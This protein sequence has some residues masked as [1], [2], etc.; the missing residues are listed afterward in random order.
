MSRSRRW[1][2]AGALLIPALAL[3]GAA[4]WMQHRVARRDESG[5][6]RLVVEHVERQ[7]A[8]ARDVA[9]GFDTRF[10]VAL[11]HRGP[12]PEAWGES[13]GTR[14]FGQ[15]EQL[16]ADSRQWHSWGNERVSCRSIDFDAASNTY[17]STFTTRL[18][19]VPAR[20]GEVRMKLTIA[21]WSSGNSN[22]PL[23]DAI[24]E[25]RFEFV[26]RQAGERIT[27]PKV[28]HHF[29][30]KAPLVNVS[31]TT[32]TSGT[33][34]V[35]AINVE[36]SFGPLPSVEGRTQYMNLVG[37]EYLQ[38]EQGRRL[39]I[40]LRP[41][42]QGMKMGSTE[43][44]Y[45]LDVSKLPRARRLTFHARFSLGESWP[46]DATAVLWDKTRPSA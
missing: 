44:S 8:T 21:A 25:S 15:P 38:D 28:S 5:P 2:E 20:E 37:E 10:V 17:K 36:I 27:T 41:C 16:D 3:G 30:L 34:A 40:R 46:L 45:T 29:P 13:A 11:G 6:F 7:A 26:A 24:P 43:F 22:R 42:L 14:A 33:R 9:E 31:R 32:I 19:D 23:P 18:A 35:P 1:S 12:T 4:L 39:P